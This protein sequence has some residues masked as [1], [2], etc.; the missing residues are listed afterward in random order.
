MALDLEELGKADRFM[1]RRGNPSEIQLNY[2]DTM[3]AFTES[4]NLLMDL[5]RSGALFKVVVAIVSV[6]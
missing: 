6:R 4:H 2:R 1:A 3:D 5:K